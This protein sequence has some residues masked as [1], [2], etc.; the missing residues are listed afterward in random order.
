MFHGVKNNGRQFMGP[1]YNP[2]KVN[3]T[4]HDYEPKTTSNEEKQ[5]GHRTN[6][7]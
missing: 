4:N 2:V 5:K 7:L 6:V 3:D 1:T